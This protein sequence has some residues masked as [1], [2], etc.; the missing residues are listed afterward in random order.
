MVIRLCYSHCIPSTQQM[1][2]GSQL[3]HS[4]C[5]LLVSSVNGHH[6]TGSQLQPQCHGQ[7]GTTLLD[8]LLSVTDLWPLPL[9][10]DYFDLFV[11]LLLLPTSVPFSDQPF[12]GLGFSLHQISRGETLEK[13]RCM[14]VLTRWMFARHCSNG[15]TNINSGKVCLLIFNSPEG[16]A[17]GQK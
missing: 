4:Y 14:K 2:T 17:W 1:S 11:S 16:E 5:A 8:R 9:K 6:C 7:S 15:F 12:W 13:V 3:W 10:E